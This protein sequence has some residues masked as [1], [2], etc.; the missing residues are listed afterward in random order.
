M[1]DLATNAVG[2]MGEAM[3][4]SAASQQP[5]TSTTNHSRSA[6]LQRLNNLQDM[7][8]IHAETGLNEAACFIS[9]TNGNL[10][11]SQNQGLAHTVGE[12]LSS[13]CGEEYNG[14]VVSLAGAVLWL[15]NGNNTKVVESVNSADSVSSANPMHNIITVLANSTTDPE[16]ESGDNSMGGF[17]NPMFNRTTSA[18][19]HSRQLEIRDEVKAAA[20]KVLKYEEKNRHRFLKTSAVDELVSSIDR[21]SIADLETKANYLKELLRAFNAQDSFVQPPVHHLV[22]AISFFEEIEDTVEATRCVH[23]GDSPVHGINFDRSTGKLVPSTVWK[24][25][26][27]RIVFRAESK[28][29]LIDSAAAFYD[30]IEHANGDTIT[31]SMWPLK[32]SMFIGNDLVFAQK[33]Q[34]SDPHS[35]KT[36][37][38][39][40]V[41]VLNFVG[42]STW[43]RKF[44]VLDVKTGSLKMYGGIGTKVEKEFLVSGCVVKFL[45]YEAPKKSFLGIG[46]S[47]NKSPQFHFNIIH[48]QRQIVSL[49][50]ETEQEAIQW[51]NTIEWVTLNEFAGNIQ[52]SNNGVEEHSTNY[53]IAEAKLQQGKRGVG[54]GMDIKMRKD[55]SIFVTQVHLPS[56]IESGIMVD[57]TILAIDDQPLK[58]LHFTQIIDIVR[59]IPVGNEVKIKYTREKLDPEERPSSGVLISFFVR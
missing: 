32:A 36:E 6:G 8:R 4:P 30:A 17:T 29:Q 21:D 39:L 43:K 18:S 19:V 53:T 54:L 27:E 31:R 44:F 25:E 33:L 12:V 55:G 1:M 23:N 47:K 57:D 40:N 34:N 3:S 7:A 46:T 59:S 15:C 11:L 50:S 16:N 14:E 13:S 41:S 10:V 35:L 48:P 26:V 42:L 22:F 20:K 37:G 24:H 49:S 2:A 28:E 52:E 51:K 58:A 9:I 5:S 56:T 45:K 38:W